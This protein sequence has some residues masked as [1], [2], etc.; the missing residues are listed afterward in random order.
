MFAPV[1][2]ALS[3][4]KGG[5]IE[6]FMVTIVVE[7]DER[8]ATATRGIPQRCGPSV[9]CVIYT[10]YLLVFRPKSRCWKRANAF[11]P[12]SAGFA[13]VHGNNALTIN[14]VE[15][16]PLDKF[17]PEVRFLLPLPISTK[18]HQENQKLTF[19]SSFRAEHQVRSCR[20]QP[21][22]RLKRS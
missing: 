7:K 15:A 2:Y 18:S 6:C 14:A 10:P 16:Y 22:P 8:E 12:V 11:L 3:R 5:E 9:L 13:T 21:S 17:S 1:Y 20:R 19:P 4:I